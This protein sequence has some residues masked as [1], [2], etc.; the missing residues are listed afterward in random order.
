MKTL[1]IWGSTGVIGSKAFEIGR[2]SGFKIEAIVGNT[3]HQEL[4]AQAKIAHP[5][6][7]GVYNREAFEIVKKEL[8]STEVQVIS[9]EE[10]PKLAHFYV[11]CCVMAVSGSIG[12][13]YTQECLGHTKRIAIAT[14]EALISGGKTLMQCAFEKKT[15]IIPIDS[16]HNAIFQC[17]VG[18]DSKNISELILTASGGPFLN[19]DEEDLKNV[20]IEQALNHPNWRMGKKN[21]IDSATC[22]NKALEIIEASILFDIDISKIKVLIHPVSI[23]HGAIK[24]RDGSIKALL[25]QPDMNIP[26]SYALN[27]PNRASSKNSDFDIL[28]LSKLEFI[29]PKPWQQRNINLAYQAMGKNKAHKLNIANEIAVEKFLAGELKFS[30]IFYFIASELFL[31]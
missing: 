3:N 26:I 23:I 8:Q 10:L 13:D 16:E 12:L 9:N 27:F 18:E 1:S 20:T 21:S 17:L 14:K 24:F 30:D 11:D 6:Y 7:V 25:S 2:R 4:I 19:Y 15:E 29:P 28:N 22:I 5:R 31:E